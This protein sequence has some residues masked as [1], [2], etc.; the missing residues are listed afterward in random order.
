[1]L[2]FCICEIILYLLGFGQ[3]VEIGLTFLLAD[4]RTVER[5]LID[6]A[7]D[8]EGRKPLYLLAFLEGIDLRI[9]GRTAGRAGEGSQK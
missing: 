9:G 1:M 7:I 4:S 5:T 3:I 6:L 8:E 2:C